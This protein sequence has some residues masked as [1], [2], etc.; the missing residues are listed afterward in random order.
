MEHRP[1]S[2]VPL[3][4]WEKHSKIVRRQ[5]K[6]EIEFLVA[7][8]PAEIWEESVRGLCYEFIPW[9]EYSSIAPQ[10]INDDPNEPASWEHYC[11][12]FSDFSRVRS[13]LS[14]YNTRLDYHRI[15]FEAASAFLEVDFS[16]YD[17]VAIEDDGF[18]EGPFRLQVYDVDGSFRSNYCELV[19]ASRL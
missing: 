18:P 12:I 11:K 16:R 19:L 2:P 3:E 8:I 17:R 9:H 15:L 10:L 4:E 1:K 7:Q 14:F 5:F 6:D 13:V